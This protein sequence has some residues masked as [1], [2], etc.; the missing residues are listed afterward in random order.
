MMAAIDWPLDDNRIR[1]GALSNTFGMVRRRA[2][3]SKRPHQGWDFTAPIGTPVHAVGAGKVIAV[4]NGGDYGLSIVHSFAHDGKL[5][6]AAYCHLLSALVR[7]GDEVKLGQFIG[8]SGDSGNAKGMTGDDLHLHFEVRTVAR[9]G[10]GLSGR[11]S[12]GEVL[13]LCPLKTTVKRAGKVKS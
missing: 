7:A 8:E 3:G 5:L 2:D 9:P 11:I 10:L 4:R 1:R 6:F 13:G 12:P